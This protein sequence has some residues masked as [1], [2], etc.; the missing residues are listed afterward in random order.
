M[1]KS[2]LGNKMKKITMVL[3]TTALLTLSAN[4]QCKPKW[5][6]AKSLSKTEKIICSDSTL[7]ASDA[8]LSNIYKKLM[9]VGAKEVK[10]NQKSW[11]RE[12]NHLSTKSEILDSYMN[13]TSYIY[14]ILKKYNSNEAKITSHEKIEKIYKA[15]VD[16]RPKV[17]ANLIKFPTNIIISG[18]NTKFATKAKFLEQYPT[19]FT[20]EYVA[21]IAK[22]KPSPDMFSNYQGI[23]LGDGVVWFTEDGDL[24][25]LNK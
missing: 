17:L 3:V 6:D 15:I 20:R 5:C 19:I 8:L 25:S 13:R 14:S 18:K 21:Q 2:I 11:L 24:K 9:S 7:K 1:T 22:E 4:A 23:M 16:N 12:R 10:A